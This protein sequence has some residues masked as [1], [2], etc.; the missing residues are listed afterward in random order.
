MLVYLWH[1][2]LESCLDQKHTF[3]WKRHVLEVLKEA[4]WRSD[5]LAE[6]EMF[7]CSPAGGP[8]HHPNSG[9]GHPLGGTFKS[10]QGQ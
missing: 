1:I 4:V 6:A 5:N 7:E 10:S 8:N 2:Y 3:D 9:D